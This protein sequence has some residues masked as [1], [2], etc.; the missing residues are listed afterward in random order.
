MVLPDGT[1][2]RAR[3]PGPPTKDCLFADPT[4]D[5]LTLLKI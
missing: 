1:V 5:G 2:L 3:L 4:R